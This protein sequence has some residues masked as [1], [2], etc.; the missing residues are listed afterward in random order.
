MSWHLQARFFCRRF[1]SFFWGAAMA[2][3][4]GQSKKHKASAHKL[5]QLVK[6]GQVPKSQEFTGAIGLGAGVFAAA[7]LAPSFAKDVTQLWTAA[8]TLGSSGNHDAV[9]SLA[10]QSLL[11]IAQMSFAVFAA[12]SIPALVAMRLQTGSVF[13]FDPVKPKVE[14]LNPVVNAKQLFSL[15]SLMKLL[16]MAARAVVIGVAIYFATKTFVGDGVR[17]SVAGER[18]ALNVFRD[19]LTQLFIW[20]VIAFVVLGTIDFAF[21]RWN[22]LK[23]QMMTQHE[24]ERE[25]KDLEGNAQIKAKRKEMAAEQTPQE[26]LKYMNVASI[27]LVASDKRVIAFYQPDET[28]KPAV[29]ILKAAGALAS[30]VLSAAEAFDVPQRLDTDLIDQLWSTITSGHELNFEQ[31]PLVRRAIDELG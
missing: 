1:F 5:R 25:Q 6:K 7:G 27:V 17:V 16:L 9:S 28:D 23:Q 12:A 19:A 20:S 13:S 31:A 10:W 14:R 4:G 11:Q 3:S 15:A 8:V 24:V 29:T 30:E 2:D 26:L 21:Q 18:A 22:F